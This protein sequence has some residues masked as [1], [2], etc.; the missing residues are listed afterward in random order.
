MRK[1]ILILSALVCFFMTGC[2]SV[3][4]NY[5]PDLSQSDWPKLN[6]E[7]TVHIGDELLVQGYSMKSKALKIEEHIDGACYDIPS[8]TYVMTG[9]DNKRDYFVAVGAGGSVIRI[10]LCDPFVGLTVPKDKAGKVCVRTVFGVNNC[11]DAKYQIVEIESEHAT[12]YQQSLIYSGMEGKQIK[13][14]YIERQGGRTN[15]SNTVS[16]DLGKSTIIN[17]KGARIQIHSANNE[18][19]S[20]T[21]LENFTSRN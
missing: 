10:G 9:Y 17:Y 20:Y 8:G 13:F 2:A 16:Y 7:T 12:N 18:V 11:Y 6:Q 15:F 1:F 3:K 5:Q 14:T 4:F 19:I 21:V